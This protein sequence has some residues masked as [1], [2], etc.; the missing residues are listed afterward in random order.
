MENKEQIYSTLKTVLIDE[1]DLDAEDITP[2][3]SLFEDLDLDSID[4]VDL[5]V[6]IRELTGKKIDPEQ[7]KSVRTLQD[8]VDC[9]AEL[10]GL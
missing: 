3:A 2:Q 5:A 1:F 8:V 6:K 10:L 9:T 7:F 4:A